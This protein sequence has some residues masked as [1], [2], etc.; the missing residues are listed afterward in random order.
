MSKIEWLAYSLVAISWSLV[1]RWTIVAYAYLESLGTQEPDIVAYDVVVD[2]PRFSCGGN[3]GGDPSEAASRSSDDEP[4]NS[5][6]HRGIIS[7][8]SPFK[9][10]TLQQCKVEAHEDAAVNQSNTTYR[11]SDL[12]GRLNYG[13]Y[14]GVTLGRY[15]LVVR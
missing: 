8:L 15:G 14:S 7:V 4:T 5:M 3:H 9:A 2:M 1:R 10:T 11:H 13:A 6:D 12:P